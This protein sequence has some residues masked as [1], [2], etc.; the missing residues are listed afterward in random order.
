MRIKG[1]PLN[2]IS[3]AEFEAIE[4]RVEDAALTEHLEED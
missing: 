4:Q 3:R 2:E 1:R